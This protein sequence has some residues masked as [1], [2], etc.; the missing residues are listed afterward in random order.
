MT[1]GSEGIGFR[2]AKAFAEVGASVVIAGR[3]TNKFQATKEKLG[4]KIQ[5]INADISQ[6]ELC[7]DNLDTVLGEFR[8]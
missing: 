2:I 4:S 3:D 6:V 7:S 8:K 5:T 1:A